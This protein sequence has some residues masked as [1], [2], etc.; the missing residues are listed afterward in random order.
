MKKKIKLSKKQIDSNSTLELD[1]L[2]FVNKI[3]LNKIFHVLL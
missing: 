3:K 1:L 2:A